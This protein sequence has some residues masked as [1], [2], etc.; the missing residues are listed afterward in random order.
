MSVPL[1]S[2]VLSVTSLP[3]TPVH[4]AAASQ[5]TSLGAALQVRLSLSGTYAQ[6]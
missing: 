2:S 3:S 6:L 5:L 4:G 1:V